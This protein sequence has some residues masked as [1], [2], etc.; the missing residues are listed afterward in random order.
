MT[1]TLPT[2]D[3]NGILTLTPVAAILGGALQVEERAGQLSLVNWKS[4][5]DDVSWAFE[6]QQPGTYRV[7]AEVAGTELSKFFVTCSGSWLTAAAKPS[8]DLNIYHK[9]DLGLIEIGAGPQ[10][11]SLL[12]VK[13]KWSH[14]NLR[15]LTLTPQVT[16]VD[17]R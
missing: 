17:E 2:P 9:V 16:A 12:P 1:G 10:N 8:G 7:E 6:G 14:L 4:F 13:R 11:L 5:L 15:S 3:A